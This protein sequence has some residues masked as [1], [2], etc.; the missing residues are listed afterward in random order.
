MADPDSQATLTSPVRNRVLVDAPSARID[1]W[2]ARQKQD[3]YTG[4][5]VRIVEQCTA[6]C[7]NNGGIAGLTY[8]SLSNDLR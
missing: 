8:R 4:D 7:P 5:L 6:G 3:P 2:R 1:H